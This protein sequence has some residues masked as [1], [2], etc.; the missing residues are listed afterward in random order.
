MVKINDLKPTNGSKEDEKKVRKSGTLP[1][2]L[3]NIHFDD[4][5]GWLKAYRSHNA[6]VV[7]RSV[8]IAFR[9]RYF[10]SQKDAAEKL[11][12]A[13]NTMNKWERGLSNI[14]WKSRND[15]VKA[16]WFKPQHFGLDVPATDF[17]EA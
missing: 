13:S 6:Q 15:L 3:L 11:G 1:K 10:L 2:E 17:T 7:A 14:R 9:R 5:E 16:G 4:A 12:I 8:I